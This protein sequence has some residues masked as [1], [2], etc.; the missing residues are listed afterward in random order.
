[1]IALICL[2]FSSLNFLTVVFCKC[3]FIYRNCSGF[4]VIYRICDDDLV[5]LSF[6]RCFRCCLCCCF[7]CRLCRCYCCCCAFFCCG[8]NRRGTCLICTISAAIRSSR[9]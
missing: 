8:H 4:L 2:G 6:C 9:R 7:C 3:F 5:C 1:M